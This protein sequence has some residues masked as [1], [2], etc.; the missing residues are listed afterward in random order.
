[1]SQTLGSGSHRPFLPQPGSRGRVVVQVLGLKSVGRQHEGQRPSLGR[2][3]VRGAACGV[4]EPPQLVGPHS[5]SG[6]PAGTCAGRAQ[7]QPGSGGQQPWAF[8]AV[9][10]LPRGLREDTEASRLGPERGSPVPH[11][12]GARAGFS[13]P[14]SPS[15]ALPP[16]SLSPGRWFCL[17]TGAPC[18]LV[19]ISEASLSRAWGSFSLYLLIDSKASMFA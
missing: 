15:A 5:W 6:R 14:Q 16:Y 11:L 17:W 12:T 9:A 13:G 8:P 3:A 19:R 10:F 2:Q 1:M 7:T 18:F 4:E